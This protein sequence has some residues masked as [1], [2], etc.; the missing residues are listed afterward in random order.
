[1]S[2]S[3]WKHFF[4]HHAVIKKIK[5]TLLK[6]LVLGRLVFTRSSNIP[7]LFEG[8]QYF[9]YNGS[10]YNRIKIN[11][12]F[13]NKKFGEFSITKKPFFFPKKNKKKR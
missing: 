13:L 7:I 9:I 8:S 10:I 5:I 12:Y 1:M 2:R 3:S 11:D 4:F 6:K